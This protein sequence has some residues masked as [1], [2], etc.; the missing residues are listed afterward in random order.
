MTAGG[1]AH[2][3]A[4]LEPFEGGGAIPEALVVGVE[5]IARLVETDAAGRADTGAG[6]DDGA[7]EAVAIAPATPGGF[8]AGGA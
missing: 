6:G 4:G 2:E 8:I 1:V 7:I 3:A 5:G